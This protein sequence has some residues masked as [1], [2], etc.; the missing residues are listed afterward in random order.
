[1]H[2]GTYQEMLLAIRNLIRV[3]KM[4]KLNQIKHQ[5]EDTKE[6]I[7]IQVETLL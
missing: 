1:M 4:K 7:M 3:G 6:I 2:H 5:L